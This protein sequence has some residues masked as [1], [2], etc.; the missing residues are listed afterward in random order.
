VS[1]I[2]I[3]GGFKSKVHHPRF[4][5]TNEQFIHALFTPSFTKPPQLCG[6]PLPLVIKIFVSRKVLPGEGL[7]PAL[8]HVFVTPVEGVLEVQEGHHQMGWQTSTASVRDDVTSYNRNRIKQVQILKLLARFDLASPALGQR[9]FDFL[10][11][12][13]IGQR[14]QR[15]AQIDHLIQAVTENIICMDGAAFKNS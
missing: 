5:W 15:M 12:H 14:H 1:L 10:P 4:Q 13:A 9:Y 7:V 6:S 8:Y 2:F 11:R 3:L